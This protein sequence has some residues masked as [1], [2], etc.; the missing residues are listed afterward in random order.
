MTA[1]VTVLDLLDTVRRRS[2]LAAR[3]WQLPSGSRECAEGG[4]EGGQTAADHVGLLQAGA[5]RGPL[6]VHRGADSLQRGERISDPG[7]VGGMLRDLLAQRVQVCARSSARRWI[8]D[9]RAAASAAARP[10][11]A[12][13]IR[14]MAKYYG[15]RARRGIKR[16]LGGHSPGGSGRSGGQKG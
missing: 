9:H 6:G 13:A 14:D 12:S 15:F 11:G 2:L 10:P 1:S 8:S 4:L 3:P 16:A 5:A 7:A